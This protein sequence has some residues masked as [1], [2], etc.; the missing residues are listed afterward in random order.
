MKTLRDYLKIFIKKGYVDFKDKHCIG[1]GLDGH[2]TISK[3][4]VVDSFISGNKRNLSLQYIA[5]DG[6]VSNILDLPVRRIYLETTYQSNKKEY[7]NIEIKEII[8]D[9]TGKT[10]YKIKPELSE[11]NGM[12]IPKDIKPYH[13]HDLY[14]I[15]D[16]CI[17]DNNLWKCIQLPDKQLNFN[18]IFWKRITS[19]ITCVRICFTCE[20][21]PDYYT[22]SFLYK[23]NILQ[24]SIYKSL[25]V[26]G[27]SVLSKTH[28]AEALKYLHGIK[29]SKD[30]SIDDLLSDEISE[31][32]G[33]DNKSKACV[34][35]VVYPNDPD[36][37]YVI[38]VIKK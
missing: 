9:E 8:D 10:N 34:K 30:Y 7:R 14:G 32:L 21:F 31:A 35:H 33:L 29:I 18:P 36:D 24:P 15:G 2:P 6:S 5:L 11:F 16:F 19:E 13:K 4:L 12:F 37:F 38:E 28:Y 1:I 22:N 17:Y 20:Y 3:D 25:K 27:N 26:F 23:N